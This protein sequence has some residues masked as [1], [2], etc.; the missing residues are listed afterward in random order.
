MAV[1][2]YTPSVFG[3]VTAKERTRLFPPGIVNNPCQVARAPE[4]VISGS[5]IDEPP[6]VLVEESM[7]TLGSVTAMSS[8][9]TGLV[10]VL[11]IVVEIVVVPPTPE[12]KHVPVLSFDVT[13]EILIL[14]VVA[15]IGVSDPKP[16]VSV[17]FTG[18]PLLM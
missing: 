11:V 7:V 18:L 5:A 2:S 8:N 12:E 16:E 13:D 10:P 15:E 14:L 17:C 1:K 3:T 6:K 4:L 9:V